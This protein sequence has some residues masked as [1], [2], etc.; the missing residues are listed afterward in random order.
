MLASRLHSPVDSVV[1]RKMKLVQD[2]EF[3]SGSFRLHTT[4]M[5]SDA[6]EIQRF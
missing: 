1:H 5:L 6:A 4:D 3:Q 2:M